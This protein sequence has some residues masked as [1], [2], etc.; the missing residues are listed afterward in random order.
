VGITVPSPAFGPG[1]SSTVDY[2]LESGARACP[3]QVFVEFRSDDGAVQSLTW[4]D[5]QDRVLAFA[6]ALHNMG[7]GPG[8]KV[9]IHLVNRPEFLVAWFACGRLGA[10]MVPTNTASTV[11]ELSFQLEHSETEICLTE[12]RFEVA[13][14]Q[15]CQQAGCVRQV[16]LASA[17]PI[18]GVDELSAPDRR[19]RAE[20][21]LAILYTSG[22]TARPKGVVVS[23]AAYGYA[24]LVVSRAIRLTDE[25]RFL[26]VLPLFHGNAQ[27]YCVMSV[28]VSR[29]T[30]LLMERFSA[31]KYFMQ[32][33]AHGAT[34]GSLFAAPARMILAQP[35]PV[36]SPT[37][38][39]RCMVFAQN[40]SEE[41]LAVWN[42]RFG[43]PIT[44]L[45][46]MTETV[47][48][49]TFNPLGS[50]ARPLS[51]GRPSLGYFCRVVDAK[52]VDVDTGEPGQLMVWGIPGLSLMSGY[53]KDPA[54]TAAVLQDG[55]LSTGDI[56]RADEDGFL[57]FVD[58]T[59][60]MMK[61]SGENVAASE[62]ENV[63]GLHPGVFDAAVIGV[64]D[65][66][67]DERIVAFVVPDQDQV[68]VQ[69]VLDWC[70]QRLAP[71]RVP[72]EVLVLRELPRTSVGKIQK[73]RLKANYLDNR[74][75][76]K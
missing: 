42:E 34:V 24:G 41:Q 74:V 68:D 48:P 33:E 21:P 61:I 43:V 50:D 52:G 49:P 5:M 63:L 19:S 51:I 18:S 45:Y 73:H 59:K 32:A 53:L 69:D 8:V 39:M 64:P 44:Q 65:D 2:L 67:R 15:A 28:L 60:D 1:G 9:N 37:V 70:R 55:W 7:V 62:V 40:L 29:A 35:P 10:V 22:T 72:S 17:M 75:E 56:V 54:A 71:F 66:I 11:D 6:A 16:L 58:R 30:L 13:A 4:Q 14:R 27:Y 25:D 36:V 3:D 76:P 26:T 47:G 38:R 46:G 57:Y 31:S 20:D 23:H 12:S